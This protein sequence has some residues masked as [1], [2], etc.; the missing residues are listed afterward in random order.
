MMKTARV[1]IVVLITMWA[2][3]ER[4]QRLDYL[5]IEDELSADPAPDCRRRRDH[6]AGR[7]G[8]RYSASGLG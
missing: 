4:S 8:L 6:P 7:G 2:M 1:M 3:S 5:G